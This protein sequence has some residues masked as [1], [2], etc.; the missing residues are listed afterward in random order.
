MYVW[1][2]YVYWV[3]CVFVC[4]VQS[5]VTVGDVLVWMC[6]R[7]EVVAPLPHMR[8][9][10]LP[11]PHTYLKQARRRSRRSV[12]VWRSW[13]IHGWNSPDCTWSHTTY[14]I[15]VKSV[16]N[17]WQGLMAL[18]PHATP[19]QTT[20]INPIPFNPNQHPNYNNKQLHQ[21]HTHPQCTASTNPLSH[22]IYHISHISYCWASQ[23]TSWCLEERRS[24]KKS[25]MYDGCHGWFCAPF[26]LF[27]M[28]E[29]G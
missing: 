27:A 14:R 23:E 13:S 12:A 8:M 9:S 3:W 2:W 7:C 16:Y 17:F 21:S 5:V 28:Q 26:C 20:S 15:S 24:S 29:T 25:I 22:S 6:K 18:A 11:L 19:P 10:A 4:H 1:W